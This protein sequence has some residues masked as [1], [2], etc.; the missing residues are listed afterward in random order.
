MHPLVI[1]EISEEA[2]RQNIAAMRRVIPTGTSLCPAVKANAYGHGI[3]QVLPVLMAEGIERVAV[4]NLIEAI[5]VRRAGWSK[6]ILCFAPILAIRDERELR[7]RAN[8]ALTEQITLTVM[9]V[10]EAK[11]LS[12]AAT[13][14]QKLARIEI[15]IDTGMGR[16]GLLP[17]LAERL[18]SEAAHLPGIVIEGVY[19]HFANTD[20]A[21]LTF[22]NYQLQRFIE[23]K[24]H[25]SSKNI[26]TGP[27]HTANSAAIF[28]LPASHLDQIRPGISLYGYWYGT[29][30][31]SELRPAMRIVSR[32]TVIKR[33]PAGHSIGYGRT[34]TTQRESIVGLVPLGYED[35]YR[36]ALSNTGIMTLEAARGRPRCHIPVV[37]RVSMD[38]TS[39]DLT[40]V[41]DVQVG[42]EITVID[43]D[44]TAPNSVESLAAQLS[45]IP[46]EIT[47]LIGQRVQRV[48]VPSFQSTV[49]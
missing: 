46:H 1:A 5:Q 6:P 35:G 7:E 44:Q 38:Q 28:R 47:C 37:G 13:R 34:F 31:P 41:G 24:D 45:T 29:D 8:L 36:R 39:V 25:L 48:A 30:R 17:D 22:A 42:D 2:I 16:M 4:A 19:S 49:I 23:I 20:E 27:Y 15:K 18:V 26:Y 11:T 21:D 33:L 10:E 12:S 40:D 14:L 9:S 3:E 32:L 43:P